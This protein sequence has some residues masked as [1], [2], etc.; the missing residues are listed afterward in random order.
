MKL[1]EE[2]RSEILDSLNINQVNFLKDELKRGKRTVFANTIATQKGLRIPEN[3]TYEDIE[4]LV[5]SWILIGY[6]DAGHVTPELKCECG[7][8]LRYQY[9][10][11][12]KQTKEERRF[13]IDHL[14]LHTGID[15]KTVAEILNGFSKIDL[16]LDEILLKLD[17]GWSI[18]VES[19]PPF[20]HLPLPKDIQ[21]HLELHLP[22]LDRQVSRIRRLIQ[23]SEME[24]R[25]SLSASILNAIK[26][27]STVE[28]EVDLFSY[29]E[30]ESSLSISEGDE[31]TETMKEAI[32]SHLQE[33]IQSARIISELLI[34]NGSTRDN[35]FVTGKPKIY[36]E[37]CGFIESLIPEHCKMLSADQNDRLY[38]WL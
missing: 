31:L 17:A 7:R 20:Q 16:E 1:P 27:Q 22:L 34:K 32:L 25:K 33:G 15:A 14:E 9:H 21:Q 18:S 3:A 6:V 11:I 4:H 23:E 35:R 30:S 5:D 2:K 12:N 37:V 29:L 26:P 8:S 10:V 28:R 13:G 38:Q 24:R 19:L 36:V